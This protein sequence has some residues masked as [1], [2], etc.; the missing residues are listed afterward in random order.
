M[1]GVFG[2]AA[3]NGVGPNM[4]RLRSIAVNTMSRGPHA[5]GFSWIDG[6]GRL[7][8]YKRVGRIVDHLDTLELAA[9]AKFLIGHCRYATHGNPSSNI[10]NHPHPADGGWIV[11]NGQI[12]HYRTIAERNGFEPVTDCDSEVLGMLI[13]GGQGGLLERCT[14]AVLESHRTPLVMMGL[15]SRPARM[16]VARLGNP[17][18]IGRCKH[19]RFYF[20][21]YADKLPGAVSEI[22]DGTIMEFTASRLKRSLQLEGV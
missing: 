4:K 11:H 15:W 14:A 21:S 9:D 7:R 10:N 8:M 13:E 3:Y 16:I 12:G 20:A 18:A 19:D 5:F 2:F 17:L 1:C 22:E 6:N